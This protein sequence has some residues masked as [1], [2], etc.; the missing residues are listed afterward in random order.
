MYVSIK[1]DILKTSNFSHTSDMS[2]EK[3]VFRET[4]RLLISGAIY[5]LMGLVALYIMY[6]TLFLVYKVFSVIVIHFSYLSDFSEEWLSLASK[7]SITL[8]EEILSVITIILVLVKAFK[9]LI[10]YSKHQHIEI[11]PLVEIAIIALLMEVV[12]N[13]WAHSMPIN[14]LFAVF[15]LW[16]LIIYASFPYFRKRVKI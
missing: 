4:T 8:T 7:M 9:I 2:K 16:L 6:M 3:D 14:W 10:S 1:Y 5:T 15:G 12:F 11:K 13:F